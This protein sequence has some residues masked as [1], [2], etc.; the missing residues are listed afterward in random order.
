M[1]KGEK[2]GGGR[3]GGTGGTGER[4]ARGRQNIRYL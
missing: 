4:G 1:R 3:R 2:E